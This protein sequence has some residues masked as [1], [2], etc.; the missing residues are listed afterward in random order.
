MSC[1]ALETVEGIAPSA[2]LP[3]SLGWLMVRS[4]YGAFF[5]AHALG[6]SL[7]RSVTQFDRP[8]I[9]A[10]ENVASIFNSLPSGVGLSR[11]T[12]VCVADSDHKTLTLKKSK[13]DGSHHALWADFV[14]LVRDT[15]NRLLNESSSNAQRA[16]A[17]LTEL[18]AALT[19]SGQSPDGNWL[20]T[21][22]NKV[23]YQHAFGAWYPYQERA[24]YYDGLYAKISC[25]RG[26][27]DQLSI[28]PQEGREVQR[29]IETCAALIALCREVTAD[30]TRRC[31]K[32]KSF[33]HYASAGL[34]RYL[35]SGLPAAP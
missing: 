22:R 6:R 13:A 18:Q 5:A 14:L 25:W 1:A 21:M 11:G 34:L 28:W 33:L 3:K 24:R 30:M 32:G 4:Y 26:N 23:N 7:G 9:N 27:S 12:F 15:A 8:A 17:K 35:E 31:P 16:A 29:F 20:S 2:S 10:I 19:D